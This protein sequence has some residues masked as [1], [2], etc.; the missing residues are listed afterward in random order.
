MHCH[1]RGRS[2]LL[3]PRTVSTTGKEG[4]VE[5]DSD[6]VEEIREGI[7]DVDVSLLALLKRRRELSAKMADVKDRAASPIRDQRREESLLVD[8]IRRGRDAGLDPHFVTRVF[9]TV[10]EDSVRLQQHMLQRR[11]NADDG[12]P[13]VMR[14]AIQGIDGSYSSLAARRFFG[15]R[16][17]DI[18]L[19]EQSTFSDVVQAV[20]DGVADYAMLPVENTTSGGINPVYD[21]LLH[22]RLSIVGEQKFKVVHCLLAPQSAD[23]STVREVYS[24]PQALAQCQR[25]LLSLPSAEAQ[26]YTDTAAS[27]RMVSEE[28]NPAKAAIASED[29]GRIYGLKVLQRDIATQKDN[30]TRFL[31][32]GRVPQKVDPRIPCKTSLVMATAQK[33][34]AL[35]DALSI[36]RHFDLNLCKLESRPI[37]G[38]PWEEMFYLDFEGNT[39]D[40]RVADALDELARCTRFLKVLGS[41]PSQDLPPTELSSE[42]RVESRANR[43]ETAPPA[44]VAS[45]SLSEAESG[46]YRR[47]SRAYKPDDTIVRVRGATIGGA[48]FAVFAG[49]STLLDRDALDDCAVVVKN[50]GAAVFRSGLRGG[51]AFDRNALET[52]A[53][54]AHSYGLPLMT[55]VST[56]DDVR[57]ATA[58][59]ILLVSAR[60][61]MNSS[62]LRSVGS[63]HKPVLLKRGWMASIDE[64]LHSAELIL[65]AGNQQVVLCERG[66]R[67]FERSTQNTLDLGAIPI[68]K[69]KTHLPIVVDPSRAAGRADLVLP[70]TLAAKAAGAHGVLFELEADTRHPASKRATLAPNEFEAVM[71][72]ILHYSGDRLS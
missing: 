33:A 36:F 38:N 66:I 63:S 19:L 64:L 15:E 71:I 17:T 27:A 31:I 58:A 47:A 7:N 60:N 40:R 61:M 14:V 34:G 50:N 25:F 68:L 8:R 10:I 16:G 55:P 59:D 32:A 44:P 22:A 2:G 45:D 18:V 57:A 23:I 46:G 51:G 69:A 20:E 53:E 48:S 42:A 26:M 13:K 54:I 3:Q 43:A 28:N 24:H 65:E 6:E 35:V 11:A 29:A 41:Y 56:P 49:P 67:T 5:P 1:S 30:F 4:G 72:E 70:L 62:L 39:A 37:I 9:H 52:A 12:G 21:V